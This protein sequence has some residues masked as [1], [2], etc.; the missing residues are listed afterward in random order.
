MVQNGEQISKVLR[1]WRGELHWLSVSGM[2]EAQLL[3]V[4]K[5][6]IEIANARPQ[7]WIRHVIVASCPISF[8]ANYRMFEPV[9]MYAYLMGSAGLDL[10]VKQRKSLITAPNTV[11]R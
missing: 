3:R 11:Q 6:S 5:L 10:D 8:I 2:R 1:K 4:Q 7:S 9:E